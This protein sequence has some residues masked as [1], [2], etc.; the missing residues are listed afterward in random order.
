MLWAKICNQWQ[1]ES[2]T[3]TV[4][5]LGKYF[6]FLP[7]TTFS[8]SLH[9]NHCIGLRLTCGHGED[10]HIL[11]P[12]HKELCSVWCTCF[13]ARWSSSCIHIDWRKDAN[14]CNS[15][16]MKQKDLHLFVVGILCMQHCTFPC[17]VYLLGLL[18]TVFTLR[19]KKNFNAIKA[20]GIRLC[21]MLLT[22]KKPLNTK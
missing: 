4:L 1:G 8:A 20:Q 11:F 15:P 18:C 12:V 9:C 2:I 16:K 22:E 10:P 5:S 3:I 19:C 13:A 17:S 14:W 21:L 7:N 6:G